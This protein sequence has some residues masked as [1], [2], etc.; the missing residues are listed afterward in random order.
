VCDTAHQAQ[1]CSAFLW[2]TCLRR[3]ISHSARRTANPKSPPHRTPP[4]L[5]LTTRPRPTAR[6]GKYEGVAKPRGVSPVQQ[7]VDYAPQLDFYA[8]DIAY[9]AAD[10]SRGE[11]PAAIRM[12]DLPHKRA[13]IRW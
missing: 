10:G 9:T 6:P 1:P 13:R 12:D 11:S 7:F 3:A 4:R 2:L 5:S 8:F